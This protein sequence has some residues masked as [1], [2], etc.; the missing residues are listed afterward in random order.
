MPQIYAINPAPP[1]HGTCRVLQ[2]DVAPTPIARCAPSKMLGNLTILAP[3]DLDTVRR[4]T[5]LRS[6]SEGAAASHGSSL[7]ILQRQ[8]ELFCERLYGRAAPFPL[9]FG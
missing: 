4:V 8:P 1:A 9:T 7:G 2:V 6:P 3:G 5:K